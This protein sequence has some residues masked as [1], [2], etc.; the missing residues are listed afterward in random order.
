MSKKVP[1]VYQQKIF[2]DFNNLEN[3]MLISAVAGSGKTTTLLFLLKLAIKKTNPNNIIFLAYNKSIQLELSKKIPLGVQCSTF[4]ALGFS[5]IRKKYRRTKLSKNKTEELYFLLGLNQEMNIEKEDLFNIDKAIQLY[6]LNDF[7]DYTRFEDYI[8]PELIMDI[9]LLDI[10]IRLFEEISTY[11]KEF[12][13][14][15]SEEFI[16]DFTDMLYLPKFLNLSFN[17][18]DYIFIDECQDLN[19]LQHYIIDR[20]THDKSRLVYVGD[21]KQSIYSFMGADAQS[22]RSILN[23]SNMVEYPLSVSYRCGKNIVNFA[24]NINPDIKAFEQNGDGIVDLS[25]NNDI[26]T[27]VEKVVSN[28]YS[29]NNIFIIC[30]NNLPLFQVYRELVMKKV[31]CYIKGEDIANTLLSLAINNTKNKTRTVRDLLIYLEAKLFAI[32]E[33]LIKRFKDVK[34]FSLD[35]HY[36]YAM[37]RERIEII[38]YLK[39]EYNLISQYDLTEK[40]KDIFQPKT[41]NAIND[42]VLMSMHKSKGLE[43]D[44]VMIYKP[45]LIPSFMATTPTDYEQE[46]NLHYVAITRAKKELMYIYDKTHNEAERT[47]TLNEISKT[48]NNEKY[49]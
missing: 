3:N 8:F 11:N 45:D 43:A 16:I 25:I 19:R 46:Y 2:E 18:L 12:I 41:E 7:N 4:H 48:I 42:V 6:K 29:N 23:K 28:T 26:H 32:G 24:Q 47:Q 31:P 39:N 35:K 40:V 36:S 33:K 13:P 5:M 20:I 21:E 27:L 22:Y 15:S 30:R 44:L 49:V 10:T 38:K 17:S 37:M 34:D 9:K 1:S 14:N